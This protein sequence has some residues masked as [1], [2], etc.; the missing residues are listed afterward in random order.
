MSGSF[1]KHER[2]SIMRRSAESQR[3][4]E[5]ATAS[6]HL[7]VVRGRMPMLG[8][9]HSLSAGIPTVIGRDRECDLTLQ[10][11][12][13]SGTHVRISPQ[14]AGGFVLTDL[15]STNG[16][17]VDG[18]RATGSW[19]LRDGEKLYLGETVLLF[20]EADETELGFL[21][22]PL[23]QLGKDRLTDLESKRGFDE[24]LDGAMTSSRLLEIPLT[25]LML[26]I[27]S[28]GAINRKHGQAAA[29]GCIRAVGRV[30][31]AVIGSHGHAC[32]YGG[33]D[34]SAFLK[35]IDRS[36]G[37]QVAELIRTSVEGLKLLHDDTV[38]EPTLSVGV[39][40]FPEDGDCV[41]DLIIAADRALYRAKIAG[42]N[43]VETR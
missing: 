41:L 26:D 7:L 34:F 12:L 33:D 25:L 2:T 40:A 38:T 5:P 10:D 20:S 23:S 30:I 1:R 22:E 17:L 39:A 37:L 35:G 9:V 14:H 4:Q 15:Q 31:D 24:A 11:P 27:D 8:C 29:A 32:R 18:K 28:L 43:R 21:R 13:V 36:G 42:G 6:A 16:T 3:A 19:S